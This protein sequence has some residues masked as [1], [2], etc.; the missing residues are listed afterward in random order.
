M[1]PIDAPYAPWGRVE[2]KF[3]H[4]VAAALLRCG[5]LYRQAALHWPVL[6]DVPWQAPQY[7]SVLDKQRLFALRF[8]PVWYTHLTPEGG[9]QLR[10][11]I[12]EAELAVVRILLEYQAD[13]MY[14]TDHRFF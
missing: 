14:R 5:E 3:F 4:D 1:A 12:R 11:E 7:L 6:V 8:N 10:Q 2:Q 9:E 13:Q